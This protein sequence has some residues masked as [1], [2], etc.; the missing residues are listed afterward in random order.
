MTNVLQLSVQESPDSNDHQVKI[1]VDGEDWLGDDQLGLDPTDLRRELGTIAAKH[2]LVG[3]CICGCVGCSDVEVRISRTNEKIEWASHDE[4]KPVFDAAQ[5]DAEVARF[6]NDHSWEPLGRRVER[7]V[8]EIFSGASTP[9]GLTFQW[10][11]TRIRLGRVHLNFANGNAWRMPEFG[12]DGTT[13]GSALA[14]ARAFL[15]DDL[16]RA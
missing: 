3:R 2:L 14:G 7:L 1:I 11:S 9:D 15:R 10:A 5:Y 6:I 8:G 13:E 4:R 16:A 12:W